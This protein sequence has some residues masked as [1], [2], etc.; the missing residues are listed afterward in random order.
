MTNRYTEWWCKMM[1]KPTACTGRFVTPAVRTLPAA[2]AGWAGDHPSSADRE[3]HSSWWLCP[4]AA[5]PRPASLGSAQR[6]DDRECDLLGKIVKDCPWWPEASAPG[7]TSG[8]THGNC[9]AKQIFHFPEWCSSTSFTL[10]SQIS[11][12]TAPLSS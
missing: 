2:P 1:L 6:G 12:S 3:V 5:H 7:V 4:R 9:T 11:N 10:P 8:A